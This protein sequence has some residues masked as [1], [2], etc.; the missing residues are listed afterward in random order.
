MSRPICTCDF[1]KAVVDEDA[2]QQLLIDVKYNRNLPTFT[3][4]PCQCDPP[5]AEKYNITEEMA[6]KTSERFSKDMLD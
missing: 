4:L 2:Y 1:M 5:C 3:I 6:N